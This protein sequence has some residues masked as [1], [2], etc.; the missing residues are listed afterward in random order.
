M[1]TE[2]MRGG[3]P[4]EASGGVSGEASGAGRGSERRVGC[5]RVGIDALDG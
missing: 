1:G 2:E 3:E 4:E 5:S